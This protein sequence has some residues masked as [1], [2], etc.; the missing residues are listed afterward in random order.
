MANR[1]KDTN[2]SQFFVTF[3]QCQHLNRKHTI[4]GRIVGD[5]VFNLMAL[6]SIDTD[7]EERPTA[8]P[9]IRRTKIVLN[10]FDDMM[11]RTQQ[12][13]QKVEVKV[14]TAANKKEEIKK[15]KKKN[16]L[17]FDLD[18]VEDGVKVKSSHEV[19]KDSKLSN[20]VAIEQQQLARRA[21]EKAD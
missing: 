12:N 14:E 7:A 11:P 15:L 10:P 21:A 2:G 13:Q 17:T 3:G 16:K 19:L 6:Q 20:E 9:V 4:F 8:P 1:G 5:T 18:E